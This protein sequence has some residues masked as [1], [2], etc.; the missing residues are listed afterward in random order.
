L[1]SRPCELHY[2]LRRIGNGAGLLGNNGVE[3]MFVR[4]YRKGE[5]RETLFNTDHIS[6]IEVEYGIFDKDAM[7]ISLTTLDAAEYP[8]TVRVYRVFV[9]DKEYILPAVKDDAVIRV[10]QDIYSH[11][12]KA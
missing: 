3:T 8:E 1:K 10:I 12:I 5:D 4:V 7:N 6:R 11:A 9:G 2:T